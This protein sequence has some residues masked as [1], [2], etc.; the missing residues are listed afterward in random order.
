MVC[1]W[2]WAPGRWLELMGHGLI[3]RARARVGFYIVTAA[4]KTRVPV[5]FPCIVFFVFATALASMLA[6]KPAT[7]ALA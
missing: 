5:F 3:F 4:E 1:V 2:A 6:A 7:N